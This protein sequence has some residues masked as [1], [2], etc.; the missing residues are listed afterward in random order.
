M[1]PTKINSLTK[2]V[3]LEVNIQ[4]TKQ[5]Y[6]RIAIAKLLLRLT[7]LILGCQIKIND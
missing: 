4:F 5:F 6:L 1:K 7:A 3:T 2:D